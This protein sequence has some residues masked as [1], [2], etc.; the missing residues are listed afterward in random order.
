MV[1]RK[2]AAKHQAINQTTTMILQL[3]HYTDEAAYYAIMREG[4]IRAGSMNKYGRGVYLTD[5]D[6]DEHDRAEVAE[7]NYGNGARRNLER[8]RLDHHIPIQIQSHEVEKVT[9][10][11]HLYPRATLHLSDYSLQNAGSNKQWIQRSKQAAMVVGGG[12]A[13]AGGAVAAVRLCQAVDGWYSN[14]SSQ[15]DQRTLELE[16]KLARI[17][18]HS[19][20]LATYTTVRSGSDG[21]CICCLQCQKRVTAD[22]R[23]GVLWSDDVD[24]Q[25]VDAR[26]SEHDMEHFTNSVA[27]F[28]GV[29]LIGI[30]WMIV[31]WYS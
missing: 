17:V 29:A 30:G 11:T 1:A 13:V 12:M 14:R 7:A 22:Y 2:N 15:Q 25:E 28:V 4:V 20:R 5:L 23:G 10:H 3:Y 18:K 6:P 9:D 27:P 19:A 24:L 21:V 26:L 31:K 8:G 16:R